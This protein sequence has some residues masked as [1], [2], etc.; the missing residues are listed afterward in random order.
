MKRQVSTCDKCGKFAEFSVTVRAA[1]NNVELKLVAPVN[2]SDKPGP[3][4]LCKDCL[5]DV[6]KD[7]NPPKAEEVKTE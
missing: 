7:I 6:F 4:D 1:S 5:K 3:I 2:E